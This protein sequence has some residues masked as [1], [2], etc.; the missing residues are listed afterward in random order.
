MKFDAYAAL[1]ALRAEGGGRAIRAT[2]AISTGL[3]STNSTNSTGRAAR[4]ENVIL[5]TPRIAAAAREAF[6][7]YSATDDPFDPGA[8]T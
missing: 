4:S 5:L 8:W 7:D 3:N 1:S 6:A 2:C